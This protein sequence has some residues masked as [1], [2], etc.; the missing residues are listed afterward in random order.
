MLRLGWSKKVLLTEVYLQRS[1]YQKSPMLSHENAELVTHAHPKC[2]TTRGRSKLLNRK[3]ELS[4][5]ND[6]SKTAQKAP[7]DPGERSAHSFPSSPAQLE[8]QSPC[9]HTSQQSILH[10]DHLLS[11]PVAKSPRR[12]KDRR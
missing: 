7:W 10:Q 1:G 12:P 2:E 8:A 5:I 4:L 3:G 9:Q 11:S 6:R